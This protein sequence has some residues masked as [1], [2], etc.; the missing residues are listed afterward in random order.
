[1]PVV[2]LGAEA[3]PADPTGVP[4]TTAPVIA[5]GRNHESEFGEIAE[6]FAEEYPRLNRV[7]FV[8]SYSLRSRVS[9]TPG[10][11][12]RYQR[13]MLI[14]TIGFIFETTLGQTICGEQATAQLHG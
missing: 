3:L 12:H 6:P 11:A 10:N 13:L 14:V 8:R 4:L 1:M 7:R 5:K 2:G 9:D